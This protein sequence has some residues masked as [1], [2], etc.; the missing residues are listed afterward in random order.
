MSTF[1]F[2]PLRPILKSSV[3]YSRHPL[4]HFHPVPLHLLYWPC[5]TELH[6][7]LLVLLS[8]YILFSWPVPLKACQ[9]CMLS[10]SPRFLGISLLYW[11]FAVFYPCN[12]LVLQPGSELCLYRLSSCFL[13]QRDF[14]DCCCTSPWIFFTCWRQLHSYHN[15]LHLWVVV[16]CP[17]LRSSKDIS[18]K[19]FYTSLGLGS[20]TFFLCVPSLLNFILSLCLVIVLPLRFFINYI[21]PVYTNSCTSLPQI[22]VSLS[23]ENFFPDV[24]YNILYSLSIFNLFKFNLSLKKEISLEGV[25]ERL[26]YQLHLIRRT[27]LKVVR[28][29]FFFFQKLQ[30]RS[31]GPHMPSDV[32]NFVSI[33]LLT[34]SSGNIYF[35]AP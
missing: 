12:C 30:E 21:F 32:V 14:P 10:C 24:L 35:S 1:I 27:D 2:S 22:L 3:Y 34:L 29:S 13:Y 19:A 25:K 6:T 4:N 18:L 23:Q 26:E 9:S 20:L 11:L 16:G 8:S 28:L 17:T 15:L 33:G 5:F 7:S 31:T